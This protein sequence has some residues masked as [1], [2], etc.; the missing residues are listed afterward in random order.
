MPTARDVM[1]SGS[2]MSTT[3]RSACFRDVLEIMDEKRL[4]VV[5][6]VD[7]G[8]LAGLITDGD[9]RRLL[10][11]TQET[12]P[13]LFM[14]RAEKVMNREPKY[15]SPGAS[16]DDCLAFLTR[17]RVWVSPVVDEDGML[18]GIVHMQ[19]LLGAMSAG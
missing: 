6:I 11:R 4:G 19:D 16:L 10:L 17:H 5:C 1:V 8:R 12:L 14:K 9:L 18:V 2:A 7:G 13:D 3:E 15:L